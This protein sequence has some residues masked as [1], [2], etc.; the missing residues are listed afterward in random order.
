MAVL[1]GTNTGNFIK[2]TLFN[3]WIYGLLGSDRIE[4]R[5]GNDRL[6]GNDGAD[7]LY[8]GL[9]NDDL[10]GGAGKDKL[11][12][13]DGD[14][15]LIGDDGNDQ[16]WGDL[17]DDS[18]LGGTGNDR[19]DGGKG[20]DYLSG[21][22][23][24]DRLYGDDGNDIIYGGDGADL[25]SGGAGD[26][27]LDGGVD[28]F[29]DNL[30]GGAGDD[31]ITVHDL[32]I[33]QGGTG[34]DTLAIAIMDYPVLTPPVPITVNLSKI[35]GSSAKSIGYHG[36]K[37]AQFEKADASIYYAAPGSLVLGTKGNDAIR[38]VGSAQGITINGGAGD[39]KI[40]A[41][42][43]NT[44]IGG[45]GSD[46]FQL[47]LYDRKSTILDFTS[48][49]DFILVEGTS[50]FFDLDLKN[51]LVTGAE[52]VATSTKGQFLYDTDDGRLFYD[53]DGTGALE[54]ILLVTLANKA[55]L[56]AAS[57]IFDL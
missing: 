45:A 36:I 13:D 4:G 49:K 32:D 17:G 52:P 11:Y 30:F 6:S 12:G 26:D 1:R 20:N 46:L 8:G 56:S 21:D 38:V 25:L 37:A 27:V 14:D 10:Y 55:K 48:K 51:P 5:D 31:V 41:G 24:N 47:D 35:T 53:Q 50:G 22:T 44:V 7:K 18:L 54:A 19:L 29:R 43:G 34:V 2:G 16:L 40:S 33:A 23:G 39:D 9:G 57:F 28:L 15:H 42:D 3:D